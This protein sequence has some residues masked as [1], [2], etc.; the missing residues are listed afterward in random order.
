MDLTPQTV[1]SYEVVMTD[2]RGSSCITTCIAD[3][4][5]HWGIPDGWNCGVSYRA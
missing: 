1:A 4:S 2:E 3:G 5:G